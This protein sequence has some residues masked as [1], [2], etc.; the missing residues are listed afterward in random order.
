MGRFPANQT[1]RREE[2]KLRISRSGRKRILNRI[3]ERNLMRNSH[4]GQF[5]SRFAHESSP[6]AMSRAPAASKNKS[7]FIG[8]YEN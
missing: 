5:P 1:D 7:L 8:K 3:R 4:S 2:G 6:S